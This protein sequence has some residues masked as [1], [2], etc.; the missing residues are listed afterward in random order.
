MVTTGDPPWGIPHD[1][2]TPHGH[3]AGIGIL[4]DTLSRLY[5]WSG[6]AWWPE[7]CGTES[8]VRCETFLIELAPKWWSFPVS[9]F[10]EMEFR[11]ISAP[12][13]FLIGKVTGEKKGRI[14]HDFQDGSSIL[15]PGDFSWFSQLS[16]S[17]ACERNGSTAP[18]QLRQWVQ[19]QWGILIQKRRWVASIQVW[20]IIIYPYLSRLDGMFLGCF[21]FFSLLLVG[22]L[23]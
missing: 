6:Q 1:L 12:S 2:R 17:G 4:Y 23:H 11:W 8:Y 7:I 22:V 10:A 21:C 3:P 16:A 5:G 18:C 13:F 19:R 14:S 9:E 15:F 20:R